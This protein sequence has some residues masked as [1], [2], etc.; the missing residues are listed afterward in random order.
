MTSRNYYC[1]LCLLRI[2]KICNWQFQ[3]Q[4]WGGQQQGWGG[5]PQQQG[6]GN[7]QQQGYGNGQQ[8]PASGGY[9]G[10]Q[11]WGQ[12]NGKMVIANM[13]IFVESQ[14]WIEKYK[15]VGWNLRILFLISYHRYTFC[16]S[17]Q[18]FDYP[19]FSLLFLLVAE[20]KIINKFK[21]KRILCMQ[22]SGYIAF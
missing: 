10:Q 14:A 21:K 11:Q 1:I 5:Q 19:W 6:Y 15:V 3:Q 13:L 17:K 2:E 20:R 7:G 9:G 4:G 8:Q 22:N 12:Q 16:A 18:W